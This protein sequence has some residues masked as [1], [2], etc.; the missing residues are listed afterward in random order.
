MPHRTDSTFA[1]RSYRSCATWIV[2]QTPTMTVPVAVIV[3]EWIERPGQKYGVRPVH[4]AAFG[5][6][7][8]LTIYTTATIVQRPPKEIFAHASGGQ[9][10]PCS[11]ASAAAVGASVVE[12]VLRPKRK[13]K[14]SSLFRRTKCNGWTTSR[15]SHSAPTCRRS[16]IY[17]ERAMANCYR[18]GGPCPTWPP[19]S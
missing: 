11:A 6:Q 10:R 2:T 8:I 14:S 5:L 1:A 7:T 17:D 19:C 12:C 15:S 3:P 16:K 18:I 4:A 13:E 9:F